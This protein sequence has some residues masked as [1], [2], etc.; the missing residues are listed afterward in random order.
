M[1]AL[2]EIVKG[3]DVDGLEAAMLSQKQVDCPVLNH[4]GPGLYIREAHMPAGTIVMGHHHKKETMNVLLKGS[5]MVWVDGK[6]VTMT[7]PETFV[8]QPG[9]KMAYIIDDVIWQNVYAT[10]E[11]DLDKLEDAIIDKSRAFIEHEELKA[12]KNEVK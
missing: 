5:L 1:N 10:D 7:A 4:F 11:T 3:G 9:R 12:L 2:A 8:S 6:L